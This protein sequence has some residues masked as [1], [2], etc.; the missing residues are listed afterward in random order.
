ME[1]ILE[2]PEFKKRKE[3]VHHIGESVYEHTLRVSFD[4]YKIAKKFGLDYKSATI[5]GL[6]HD[7]YEKPWQEKHEK[8][9]FF[10]KHGFVHAEQARKNAKKYFPELI[11]PKI[12]DII[13]KHMFPLNRKIPKYKE[14]WLVSFVDKADSIDFLMHP[15][16]LIRLC[17]HKEIKTREQTIKR[18]IRQIKKKIH[19]N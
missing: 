15:A 14:S 11:T 19:R 7:F 1:P 2:H 8:T 5:G 12:E 6:L 17:F 4:S 13:K 18:H 3:F 9:P 10:Q 16:A